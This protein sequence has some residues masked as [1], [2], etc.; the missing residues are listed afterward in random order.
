MKIRRIFW[1]KEYIVKKPSI[2]G[3]NLGGGVMYCMELA[4][5]WLY[6]KAVGVVAAC[7]LQWVITCV[8]CLFAEWWDNF[9]ETPHCFSPPPPGVIILPFMSIN[10]CPCRHRICLLFRGVWLASRVITF[11]L[12][13]ISCRM[14]M[15]DVTCVHTSCLQVERFSMWAV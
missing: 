12:G 7:V 14:Q 3:H 5:S 9:K 15:A 13:G 10:T 4:A 6:V 2:D 1:V 11:T 8:R